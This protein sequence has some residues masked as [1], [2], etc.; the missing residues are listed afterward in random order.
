VNQ[1]LG[2]KRAILV[3]LGP[4]LLMYSLIMVIPVVWSFGFALYRGNLI[5]GFTFV[6]LSN[7]A[8]LFTDAQ[9]G[10]A[11]RFTL[12]YTLVMST[13]QIVVGYSLALFYTFVLRRSSNLI[14]T[15]VFFPVVLPSV[16]V[17][18]MF[19]RLFAVAP[20]TGPVASALNVV[21]V[22]PFD[23]FAS[24]GTAFW[25]IILMDLWRSMG[26][27]GVLLYSGIIDI[28][29]DILEAAR[30]DGARGWRLI[31][32]VV[33][34]LSLPILISAII[35]SL[36][37]SL[38]VFDTIVA[39]TN[40]G[41]GYQTTPITLLM[42]QTSFFYSS[43]GYGSSMAILISVMCLTVTAFIFKYSRRDLTVSEIA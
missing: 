34:P 9:V 37:A 39:L 5:E 13:G 42:F 14:R 32:S 19:S 1:V 40:G 3:L 33:L 8:R 26:F 24:A 17:G 7:F 4:A 20:N 2:D 21:G 30:I 29:V 28:P 6:G 35:F 12:L 38:K 18:L 10:S 23:F 15:L 22:A 36:N 27:Y 43:F 41:P 25:V 31:R 11:V 16:A